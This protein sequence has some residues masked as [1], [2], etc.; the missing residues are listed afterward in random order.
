MVLST[1]VDELQQLL[2]LKLEP[3]LGSLELELGLAPGPEL[4]LELE[5]QPEA[6]LDLGPG[7]EPTRGMVLQRAQP[8]TRIEAGAYSRASPR[9]S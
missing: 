8:G 4:G 5:P 1:Q 6:G 9:E 3:D 2:E 7:L